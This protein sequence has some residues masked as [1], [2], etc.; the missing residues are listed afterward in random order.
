MEKEDM[1]FS[2]TLQTEILEDITAF[3]EL[4][5]PLDTST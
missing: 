1:V 5:T 4:H 3:T 2:S